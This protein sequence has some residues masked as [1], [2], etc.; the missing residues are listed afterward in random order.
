MFYVFFGE[1]AT[2]IVDEFAIKHV[3]KVVRLIVARPVA[4]EL[5][6]LTIT[7]NIARKR[8]LLRDIA[9]EIRTIERDI[10]H[11]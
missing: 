1:I 4:H 3:V 6:W 7:K 8:N 2:E 11:I 5:A 10:Y 9:G